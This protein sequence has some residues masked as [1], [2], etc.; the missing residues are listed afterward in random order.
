MSDS[1]TYGHFLPPYI[2]EML[3]SVLQTKNLEGIENAHFFNFDDL[4][5]TKRKMY[6]TWKKQTK[7]IK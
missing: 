4:K 3:R 6:T 7:Y 2:E 5:I 1:L